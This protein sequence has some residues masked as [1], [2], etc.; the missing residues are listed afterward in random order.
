MSL[1]SGLPSF[2]DLPP[3]DGMPQ[4]CAS[5]VFDQDSQKDKLGTLNLLTLDVVQSAAA[6]IKEGVLVLLK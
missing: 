2:N 6:E 4:D 3:V 1:L 5:G